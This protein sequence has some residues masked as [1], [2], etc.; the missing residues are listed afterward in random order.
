[1]ISPAE[2]KDGCAARHRLDHRQAEWLQPIGREQQR[3][4]LAQEFGLAALITRPQNRSE[5][6]PDR[7]IRIARTLGIPLKIAAEVDRADEAYFREEIA[8]LLTQLGV[9]RSMPLAAAVADYHNHRV[10]KLKEAG[11]APEAAHVLPG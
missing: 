8:P 11:A 3:L 7:A 1:M 5:K 4:R 6:R 9:S 2:S 10:K